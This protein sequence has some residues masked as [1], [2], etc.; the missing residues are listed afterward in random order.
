M[1]AKPHMGVKLDGA[2]SWE[3]RL[4][5]SSRPL[6]VSDHRYSL[7]LQHHFGAE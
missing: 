6:I 3:G 4:L 5:P 2:K 7:N 1:L